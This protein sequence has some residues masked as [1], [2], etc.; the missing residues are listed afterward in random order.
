MTAGCCEVL[1]LVNLNDAAQLGVN[2]VGCWRRPR[3][4][5]PEDGG[6]APEPRMDLRQRRDNGRWRTVDDDGIEVP[7]AGQPG[8]ASSQRQR[9]T[10]RER[11]VENVEMQT[12]HGGVSA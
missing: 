8:D 10:R 1:D 5:G 4:L 11:R 9:Q 6:V 2:Q 12:R 7:T 3:C